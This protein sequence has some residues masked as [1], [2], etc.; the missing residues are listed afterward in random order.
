MRVWTKRADD[1]A[2]A[3]ALAAREIPPAMRFAP[4]ETRRF[5]GTTERR[6]DLV[7][8]FA[9]NY[10]F[11]DI[12]PFV[13][14]LLNHGRNVHLTIFAESMDEAFHLLAERLNIEVIPIEVALLREW[15][16]CN[17][18][19][20][21]YDE[22]LRSTAGKWRN[23]LIS[24]VR[25]VVFQADPFEES[26]PAPVVFAAEDGPIGTSGVN[27]EWLTQRYSP[28]IA[29]TLATRPIVCAGTTIGTI[30]GI[31]A[32]VEAIWHEIGSDSYDHRRAFDQGSHNYIAW[33][34]APHWAYVDPE[35]R[36]MAT[37][38][39]TKP[40][41]ITIVN[42]LIM[43]DGKAPPIVHQ[44]DR[45]PGLVGFINQSPHMHLRS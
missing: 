45:K 40:E 14:S 16:I 21:L 42:G 32:Y 5:G 19:F 30:S 7:L 41:R 27:H 8:T 33:H 9:S 43:V 11:A 17:L 23:V 10:G 35:D 39:M 2:T 29:G 26:F 24:D 34:L 3:A 1:P 4:A 38:G 22:Y 25:D 12:E 28:D 20:H 37:I 6:P 18:R 15:H 36:I 44:W 13:A 31:M